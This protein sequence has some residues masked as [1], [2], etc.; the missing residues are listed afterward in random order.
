MPFGAKAGILQN[1]FGHPFNLRLGDRV[2]P[3]FLFS[4]AAHQGLELFQKTLGFLGVVPVNFFQLGPGPGSGILR[5]LFPA[6]GA[7]IAP[8]ELATG[9][10]AYFVGKPTL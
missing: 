9:S 7:L 3:L 2:N 4:Q 5:G 6:T 1:V 8:I 10:K